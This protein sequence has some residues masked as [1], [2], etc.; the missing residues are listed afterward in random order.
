MGNRITNRR[1]YSDEEYL[2]KSLKMSNGL[3]S[4]FIAVLALNASHLARTDREIQFAI[5]LASRD[6][7][8][9]GI[10]TVGFDLRDMP[11][12]VAHFEA[13]KGFLLRVI[14]AAKAKHLWER[15]DYEPREVWTLAS[16]QKF[17]EL[18]EDFTEAF[19][20]AGEIEPDNEPGPPEK[21]PIHHIYLH[22][23]GCVICN[24]Q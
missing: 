7:A 2:D 24:D 3:T 5:W 17:R 12:S 1:D 9:V 10:G 4:V 21:C 14:D 8:V 23:A 19:I 18:I 15:L 11:W 13:E 6:Q 22:W 20:E 16:L